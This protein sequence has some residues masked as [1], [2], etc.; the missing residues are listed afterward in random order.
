[1]VNNKQVITMDDKFPSGKSVR[2]VRKDAKKLAK[3]SGISPH[4]ALD[5]CAKNNGL[6]GGWAK[7]LSYIIEV[8]MRQPTRVEPQVRKEQILAAAITV[9]RADGYN[10]MT[11]LKVANAAGVS[12]GQVS[13]I[14]NTMNQLRRDVI[15]YAVRELEKGIR[16]EVMLDVVACGLVADQSAARAASDAIKKAAVARFM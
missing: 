5:L 1:M 14:F 13:T 10:A 16:D 4:E 7:A 11:R 15:R 12:T 2:R 9:V 3:E 6:D 8:G